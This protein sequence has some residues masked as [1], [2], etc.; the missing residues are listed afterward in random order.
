[1]TA[2]S[3]VFI[4]RLIG[5]EV[6]DPNG[7]PV[8]RLRDIVVTLRSGGQPPR[9]LGLVVE[10]PGKRRIFVPMTRVTDLDARQVVTNGVV[11][12][13]RFSQ[14]PTERLVAGQ[15]IATSA[16]LLDGSRGTIIDIA[17][18]RTRRQ[19][20]D[21]SQVHLRRGGRGPL[22]R[23]DTLTVAVAEVTGLTL[24]GAPLDAERML[25]SFAGLRP[26]DLAGEMHRMTEDRRS[27]LAAVLDDE[28]LADVLEELPEDDQVAILGGLSE[29]RAA[30]VLEAMAPDD[31]A[32]L[33]GE[34][35]PEKAARFLSL[36]E[37]E[38]AADVRR[39][40]IYDDA[41][42]GGMMTS[43]PVVLT[44]DATVAEALAR[45][46]SADL[47]PALAS[48][49]YVCRPPTETP[50]GRFLG[51]AHFQRLLREPPAMLV[52]GV[53]DPDLEPVA[54]AAPLPQVTRYFA[55]YNLVAVPV[56]DDNGR[57]LGAVTV[58]DLIDHMLPEDWRGDTPLD[59][60]A[61]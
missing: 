21:L 39:L 18:D 16:D 45:I 59:L 26:A 47:S 4:A 20:W 58:D 49:V 56:V 19:D 61:E 7:D 27:A 11:N 51:A 52:S 43:E 42:A 48:Q 17:M 46:R 29:D 33:L 1:M 10:V 40:L 53:V 23:G 12:L 31:A 41:T 55:T 34:L 14:R 25:A 35:E 36:M 37:P 60:S 22:R 44:P 15:L 8:G 54:P 6:F 28:R 50:T 57:L 24:D 32:D 30:D 9:V 5:V 2:P 3:R 38:E 13:R